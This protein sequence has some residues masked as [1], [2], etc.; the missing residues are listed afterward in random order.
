[1]QEAVAPRR[2][3][4]L[5]IGADETSP[6]GNGMMMQALPSV[7][8]LV[9]VGTEEITMHPLSRCSNNSSAPRDWTRQDGRSKAQRGR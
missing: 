9:G 2:L 5:W 8:D 7:E 3:L 4:R 1:M 6:V